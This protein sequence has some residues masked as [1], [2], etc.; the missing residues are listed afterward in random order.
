MQVVVV[1]FAC[2][3]SFFPAED[4]ILASLGSTKNKSIWVAQQLDK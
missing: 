3:V 4:L 2:F 1:L